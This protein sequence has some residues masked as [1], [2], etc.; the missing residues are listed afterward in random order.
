MPLLHAHP[1]HTSRRG[2]IKKCRG[3]PKGLFALGRSEP[4]AECDRGTCI[5]VVSYDGAPQENVKRLT[6]QDKRST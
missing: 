3:N 4:T 6:I 1:R 2:R 5:L